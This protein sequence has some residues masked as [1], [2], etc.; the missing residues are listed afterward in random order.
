MKAN[1]TFR[2]IENHWALTWILCW[3]SFASL[4]LLHS[5]DFKLQLSLQGSSF[6]SWK[7]ILGFDVFGRELLL[8]VSRA[9][10][11]STA[12]ALL[13][14]F[15]TLV[16]GLVLGTVLATTP[17]IFQSL[18]VRFLEFLLAFPSLLFAL[19]W[20]VLYGPG[21]DTLIFS[22][23][24]GTVPSTIRMSYVHTR[25]LLQEEYILSSQSLGASF[26]WI[27]TRHLIPSNFIFVSV[28]IPN[29]FAQALVAEATLSF[30]GL[31]APIGADTWGSLLAQGKEYLIE[32]PHLSFGAGL[33]L[34]FT[35]LALQNLT[36]NKV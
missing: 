30:L 21:W 16:L 29:L 15:L 34:V 17:S 18:G 8:I 31:G 32:A 5:S 12:F 35:V 26:S 2:W 36:R 25:E 4:A 3:F 24:I 7:T 6:D 14:T 1:H 13:A 11:A 9:A 27:L 10:I 33:P 19:G 23:L 28:K 22:I 20:A